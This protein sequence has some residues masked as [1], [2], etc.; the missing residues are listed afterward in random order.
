MGPDP[1]KQSKQLYIPF[2]HF[3]LDH[4]LMKALFLEHSV[5][6]DT[7]L[8][9]FILSHNRQYKSNITTKCCQK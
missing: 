1:N 7:F 6:K 5:G 3:H 2:V 9:S 4:E 8:L